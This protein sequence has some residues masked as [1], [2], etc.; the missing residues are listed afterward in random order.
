MTS[1]G[2]LREREVLERKSGGGEVTL[3][4]CYILGFSKI[5]RESME[6][7]EEDKQTYYENETVTLEN[8]RLYQSDAGVGLELNLR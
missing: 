4:K 7:S 1:G 3:R 5:R 8:G 2:Y 6:D